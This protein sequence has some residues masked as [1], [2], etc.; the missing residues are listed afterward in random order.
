MTLSRPLFSLT[1]KANFIILLSKISIINRIIHKISIKYKSF[2]SLG[3][4]LNSFTDDPKFLFSPYFKG[5]L[6]FFGKK[7]KM[8]EHQCRCIDERYGQYREQG[9][10]LLWGYLF[11]TALNAWLFFFWSA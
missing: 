4:N 7:G 1:G 2:F 9:H 6:K 10:C 5:G 3:K 8:R 11:F